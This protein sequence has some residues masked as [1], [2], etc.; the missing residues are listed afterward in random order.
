MRLNLL[1]CLL[2][3]LFAISASAQN[4]QPLTLTSIPF[5]GADLST[6]WKYSTM[7]NKAFADS[8]FDDAKWDTISPS[9]AVYQLPQLQS[10]KIGWLRLHINV[11]AELGNK[12]LLLQVFQNCA[13]EIYLDGQLVERFGVLSAD[14]AKAVPI[15]TNQVYREVYLTPGTEHVFAVRFA[16]YQGASLIRNRGS[17]FWLTLDNFADY[18]AI[19]Q[20]ELPRNEV[21]IIVVSFFFL[22]S[23]LH[24]AFYRYDPQ[25]RANLYFAVYNIISTIAFALVSAQNYVQDAR[26]YAIVFTGSFLIPIAG[27]VF[28]V[29][30]LGSLFNFN[31]KG[32]I[33][34]MWIVYTLLALMILFIGLN[35]PLFFGILAAFTLI[36]FG[37]TIKALY[38]RKRGAGIIA[39]GLFV[40]ILGGVGLMSFYFSF[41]DLQL[42]QNALLEEILTLMTE[43]AP[44]LGVSIYLAREFALDSSLLRDKLV[45]VETLS[46]Q[47]LSYE[48]E[49]QEI[50]SRQKEELEEQVVSRTAELQASLHHLQSAQAQL[51]QSE[52]MAS[53]GEL[54]AGIAHEIQNPLNFVNNFSEVSIELLQELKEEAEAGNKE[55]VLGI[56]DDLTQNLEKISNHG[57]RAD[58]IVKAMLQH[59]RATSGQKEP[60]DINT[61]TAEYLRLAY[62][63][64]RAKDK[65][66]NADLITHFDESIP[67]IDVISQE[68]GR[69]LLN[70]FNNAFYAVQQ[71][72]KNMGEDYKPS[73]EVVTL[74]KA[75]ALEILIKDNGEGIADAIKDKIMQPFFTTKPTGQGTGLG[76]SLSY[77]IIVK[78]HGG[79]IVVQSKKGEGA[80]FI[81]TL[82]V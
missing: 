23:L 74:K 64:L 27:Y 4:K 17:L 55:D 12:A 22:L 7:D 18:Q 70:L 62:H 16:M 46:A 28:L 26:F 35:L 81:I 67:L 75:N 1:R 34:L 71:K 79:N 14:P 8:S 50:L 68:I 40:A 53:L 36:L 45:Q 15:G 66:F 76:L 51:I 24:L 63:G 11:G 19:K 57:K 30:A 32:L 3:I 56:A 82:P 44:A 13:S 25:R 69:V 65:N 38:E 48:Q 33:A 5:G 73:I 49:K 80:T 42:T 10:V 6:G 78:G 60:T 29:R 72:A 77:D 54:T 39:F 9:K 31:L 58:G 20:L 37:I 21:Y 43:A 47:N 2:P 61:L 41:L 52:K 59:S